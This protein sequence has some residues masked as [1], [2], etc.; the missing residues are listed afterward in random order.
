VDSVGFHG[1]SDLAGSRPRHLHFP[2]CHI[3]RLQE[4]VFWKLLSVSTK[5]KA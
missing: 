3:S 2:S 1:I 4:A 5:D